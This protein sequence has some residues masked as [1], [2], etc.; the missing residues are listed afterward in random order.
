MYVDNLIIVT[1]TPEKMKTVKNGLATRFCMKDLGRLHYCLGI[2]IEY[3]INNSMYIHQ[4]Q[5]IQTLLERYELSEMKSSSTPADTSVK[6][7]KDDGLSKPVNPMKYQSMVGS[8]LY[9]DIATRPDI[10]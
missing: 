6:L 10:A 3:D 4:R 8:L 1:R 7:V 5:Y 2:T 9:A